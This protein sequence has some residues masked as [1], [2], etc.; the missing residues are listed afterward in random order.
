MVRLAACQASIPIRLSQ[1]T[2]P[3]FAAL[4]SGYSSPGSC[5]ALLRCTTRLRVRTGSYC[6]QP[7]F[8]QQASRKLRAGTVVQRVHRPLHQPHRSAPTS[9][10]PVRLCNP[11]QYAKSIAFRSNARGRQWLNAQGRR[12]LCR[13]RGN[14]R[15]IDEARVHLD[16]TMPMTQMTG[17]TSLSA[18]R[19]GL[20]T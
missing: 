11:R 17:L 5:R 15:A 18:F 6:F 4:G 20:R 16:K 19:P 12:P 7:N 3:G 2:R 13:H 14:R 9:A 1:F 10:A 8:A